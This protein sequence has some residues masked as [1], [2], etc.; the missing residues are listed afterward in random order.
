MLT[1][2]ARI[3]PIIAAALPPLGV[4]FP[5]AK[6]FRKSSMLVSLTIVIHHVMV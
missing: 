6:S 2:A 4:G 1:G 5:L 3:A